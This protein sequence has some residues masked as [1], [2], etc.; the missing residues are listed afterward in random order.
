MACICGSDLFA[1]ALHYLAALLH[2]ADEVFKRK[3]ARNAERRKFAEAESHGSGRYDAF[4]FQHFGTHERGGRDRELTVVAA[5][6]FRLIRFPQKL[7]H[8]SAGNR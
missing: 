3:D 8:I 5:A 1:H 6:Q 7:C 2:D 4:R